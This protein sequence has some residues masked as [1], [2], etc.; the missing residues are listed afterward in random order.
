MGDLDL[1]LLLDLTFILL[2]LLPDIMGLG[3][4]D[5]DLFQ[6]GRGR[7]RGGETPSLLLLLLLLSLRTGENLLAL[8]GEYDGDLA[9]LGGE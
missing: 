6:G 5:L 3:L 9:L 1:D 8:G 4:L 2:R 7:P